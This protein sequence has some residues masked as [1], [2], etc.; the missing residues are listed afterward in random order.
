[1][2]K[3]V[4]T[5]NYPINLHGKDLKMAKYLITQMG[6]ANG[7]LGA[8]LRY[9]SQK[10]TMPDDKGK[11]LLNDIAT[12]E[13]GHVEMIAT[14]VY[15]LLKNA[16]LDE[17]K[18]AGLEGYYVEHKKGIFPIDTS[19]IPFTCAYFAVTGDPIADLSE[20]MAAEQKA[21]A[22]YESLINITNDEEIVKVLLFLRQREI[23]HF[24]RFHEL[25]KYYKNKGY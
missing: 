21:R 20:D 2:Y 1:M 12:E 18:E 22:T 8:A 7:E 14:M 25:Y 19:G 13:M 11:S 6:G 23:I 24:N 17:L 9:F 5:L 3:Y 15:Q 10:F 16:S 4:K